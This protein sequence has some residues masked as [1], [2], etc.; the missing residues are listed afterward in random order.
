MHKM[1]VGCKRY[2][3]EANKPLFLIWEKDVSKQEKFLRICKVFED[4]YIG[5]QKCFSVFKLVYSFSIIEKLIR[6]KKFHCW[7][8]SFKA[9]K[10]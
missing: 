2:T 6:I 4:S 3:N 7:Q 9:D 10:F 8:E 1:S 5:N